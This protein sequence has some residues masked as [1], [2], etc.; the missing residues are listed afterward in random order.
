MKFRTFFIPIGI[1]WIVAGIL[2]WHFTL[3]PTVPGKSVTR[4]IDSDSI[5]VSKV[6]D[7]DTLDVTQ[8]GETRRVRLIGI[9]TPETLDPRKPVECFGRE[10]SNFSKHVATGKVVTL[11]S[12]PTQDV[13]DKYGRLLAYVYLPDGTML[14]KKLVAE[15]YAYEYTYK[16]P[17]LRQGEFKEAEKNA[18]SMA[19]GLWNEKTCS[20]KK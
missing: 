4:K 11:E 9:N 15:G 20:G 1:L 17:Y 13:V 16:T 2:V 8:R 3:T 19:L 12:D 10:A 6:I 18:R 5:F 7:G 14:N